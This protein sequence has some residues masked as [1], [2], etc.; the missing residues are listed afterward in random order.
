MGRPPPPIWRNFKCKKKDLIFKIRMG[1]ERYVL[2]CITPS[3]RSGLGVGRKHL[4]WS[5]TQIIIKTHCS[6][7]LGAPEHLT[8][9]NIF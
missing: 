6:N 9:I 2:R 8:N 3:I 7:I 5:E 4:H 1:S